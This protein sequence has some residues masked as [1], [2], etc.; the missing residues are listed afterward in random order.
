MIRIVKEYAE[1]KKEIMDTAQALFYQNGYANT[2]VNFII[3]SIGISKGTFYHYFKSKEDLL[4]KIVDEF[5]K[6]IMLKLELV[7]N[8][9]SLDAISKLNEFYRQAGMYK[10]E[11]IDIIK[12]LVNALYNDKNL[13]LRY[14]MNNQ[15][16]E[17]LIPLMSEIFEQGKNEGSFDIE[18]PIEIAR[19]VLL[20]GTSLGEYNAKL[21]MSLNKNP[22]NIEEMKK[23]FNI[24]QT[25]VQRILGAPEGSI[26]L[27]D[28]EIVNAIME[29]Y[30]E[31]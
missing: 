12:T 28:E 17:I 14:K 18:H 21:M 30:N 7:V 20:F 3:E 4:D 27:F 11:N 9:N 23:H 5:T 16:V 26:E 13:L 8:D 22:D 29:K 1:R 6:E 2:S 31:S 25:S 15:S 10:A 24:Y 19:I